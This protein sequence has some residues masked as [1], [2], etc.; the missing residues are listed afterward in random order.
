[1]NLQ[2]SINELFATYPKVDTFYKTSDNQFFE[3]KPN[4]DAHGQ[5]LKDKGVATVTRSMA[6]VPAPAAAVD[7]AI[8][9]PEATQP[10]DQ[11]IA[12]K[13]K[14]DQD[15]QDALAAQLAEKEKADEAA[16]ELAA[17]EKAAQD[18]AQKTDADKTAQDALAAELN[19]EAAN[20]V[21]NVVVDGQK[22]S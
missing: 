7:G 22:K 21:D 8:I 10:T 3:L 12:D 20:S 4:A 16:A 19:S 1:M 13:A 15:A 9:N 17:Q 2:E 5:S 14:A 6:I 18:E 11:E